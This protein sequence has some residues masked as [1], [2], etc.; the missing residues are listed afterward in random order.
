[1]KK[2]SMLVD[3]LVGRRV[4][5]EPF[6]EDIL[7][8][9]MNDVAFHINTCTPFNSLFQPIR[10]TLVVFYHTIIPSNAVYVHARSSMKYEGEIQ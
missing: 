9:Y 3:V 1:M 4:I 8:I 7:G 2:C 5:P 10:L 6:I